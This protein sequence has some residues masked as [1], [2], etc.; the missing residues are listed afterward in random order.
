MSLSPQGLLRSPWLRGAIFAVVLAA[1]AWFL[2]G[3][4]DELRRYPWQIGPLPLLISVVWGAI[5]FGG[6]ALCWTLL[7][8]TMGGA[9]H[10]VGLIAGAYIWL[11][12]MLARYVPGNIWHIVG[13]V[14]LA[15]RLGVRKSQVAAS[16]TVEQ[17][18]TL[19][20]TAAIFG[21]SLPFWRGDAGAERWLL[22]LIPLGLTGLH[23]RIL[24]ALLGWT[25]A[26]L[27]RPELAWPYRYG[28]M[29]GLLGAF[30]AA[31]LAAGLALYVI[32]AALTLIAP[33]Q[34]PF[35]IGASALAWALGYLSLLTP[36][37]LGVREAILTALLA[38]IFPLPV[39]I[40]GS[41]LHRLA[42]TLGEIVAVGAIMLLVRVR[43]TLAPEHTE[44]L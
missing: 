5:Y 42:L 26:R 22:A 7:L 35:L 18:L 38:Q 30:A 3:Q 34:I 40:V 16:A 27:E 2:W 11:S 20:G 32:V 28:T 1:W 21:L 14:A 8:R 6:L 4:L 12:T 39:A 44:P 37:G 23:P 10:E 41:L 17:L 29:L 13:R 33:A 43:P 15:G 31:N 24:G 25:A 9:A 19:M 36:S